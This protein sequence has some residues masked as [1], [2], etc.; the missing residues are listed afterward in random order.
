MQSIKL[1]LVDYSHSYSGG[2]C[3]HIAS[4]RIPPFSLDKISKINNEFFKTN[5][6][7]LFKSIS[8]NKNL[9]IVVNLVYSVVNYIMTYYISK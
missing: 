2:Y 5:K 3:A 8:T 7:S 1:K 4:E 9:K 6:I